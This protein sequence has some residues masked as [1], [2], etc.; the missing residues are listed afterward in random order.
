MQSEGVR[1]T[2]DHTANAEWV[3][4]SFERRMGWVTIAWLS[5]LLFIPAMFLLQRL[6]SFLPEPYPGLVAFFSF[7]PLFA[8]ARYRVACWPCPRCGVQFFRPHPGLLP[9]PYLP[10]ARTC[11][12][13]GLARPETR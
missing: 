4:E 6:L 8:Y 3:R 9:A 11:W 1:P 10:W 5:F 13:C 7:V 12:K 2:A